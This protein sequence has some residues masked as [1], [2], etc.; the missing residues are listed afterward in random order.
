VSLWVRGGTASPNE[1]GPRPVPWVAG[2]APAVHG[3][4]HARGGEADVLDFSANGNVIGPPP[5]LSHAIARVDVSRYPDPEA[6]ALREVIAA[7]ERVTV[8]S[9]A[10]GNGSSE[11]IWAVARA[12]LAPGDVALICGPTYGEYAVASAAA[13]SP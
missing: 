2:L 9:V 6:L 7:R 13:Y 10:V 5:G 1:E 12:Y 11:L 8:E 3:A 4:F